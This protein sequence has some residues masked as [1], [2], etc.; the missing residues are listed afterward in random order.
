M[1]RTP[2]SSTAIPRLLEKIFHL[3]RLGTHWQTEALAGVIT[4]ITLAY[5]LVVTPSILSPVIYLEQPGDLFDQLVFATALVSGISTIVMGGLANLPFT[6]APGMGISSLFVFSI[7]I[8]LKLDW[9]LALA[10]VLM[11][12]LLVVA[13]SLTRLR[14]T[15][16]A[17]I[18]PS[19]K[20][21][22]VAGI[23]L[24]IA[25]IALSGDP[26]PPT[27]GM[28]IIVASDATKTALGSF[29]NPITLTALF[30]LLVTAMMMVRQVKGSLLWGIL[31]TALLGWILG[32]APWPQGIMA[33]PQWPT[34]IFG[35]A[36]AGFRYLTVDQLGNFVAAVFML[37]FI[38]VLDSI[39][40]IVGLSQPLATGTSTSTATPPKSGKAMLALGLGNTFGALM[41]VSPMVPYL[42]SAA[43]IAEG[44]R[45]GLTALVTAGVLLISLL[46]IP[47]LSAVP[48]FA[49]APA[50][51]LIGV[52]MLGS[53]VK[54]INWDDL[55]EAIP[56]FLIILTVPTAFSLADGLALGFISYVLIK[57]FQGKFCR[58]QWP[59]VLIAILSGLYFV[60]ITLQGS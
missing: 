44:G 34:D 40:A 42:E 48:A 7:V 37:T 16:I 17:A 49:T 33:V 60:L 55:S 24:F 11:Q 59:C 18:P 39:G 36:I 38:T 53:S 21:A 9:H 15:L 3:H 45:S 52:L 26:V 8:N 23:G 57:T 28:G 51:V 14:E 35:Q 46:F 5:T 25:Y 54:A 43:G 20:Y 2:A 29:Q 4:A 10:A 56:A 31:S 12:G 6:L 41:G 58:L 22:I 19:L 50:L 32:V 1:T 27:L 47:L 30:G 13:L